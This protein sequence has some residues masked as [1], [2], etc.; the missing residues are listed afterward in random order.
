LP[1]K[2]ANRLACCGCKTS[3]HYGSLSTIP[4]NK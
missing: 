4:S 1:E 3:E 2:E